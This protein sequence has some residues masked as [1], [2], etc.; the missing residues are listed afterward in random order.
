MAPPCAEG[1]VFMKIRSCSLPVDKRNSGR[2][3][4]CKVLRKREDRERAEG[5]FCSPEPMIKR[6]APDGP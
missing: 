1:W 2:R 6:D 5:N 4:M 3:C